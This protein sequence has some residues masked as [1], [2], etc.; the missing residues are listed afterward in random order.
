MK[1]NPIENTS[2][3][4]FA[5][6][7]I[8]GSTK[9]SLTIQSEVSSTLSGLSVC[10]NGGG[11]PGKIYDSFYNKPP[12]NGSATSP[13]V[14]NLQPINNTTYISFVPNGFLQPNKPTLGIQSDNSSPLSGLYVRT[15]DG[16]TGATGGQIY[17]SCFNKPPF[18]AT[19]TSDLDMATHQINNCN[20]MTIV[21]SPNV[22]TAVQSNGGSGL[23]ITS[24][25]FAT[26]TGIIYDSYYNKPTLT[27]VLTAGA[28]AGNLNITGVNNISVVQSNSTDIVNTNSISTETLIVNTITQILDLTL[29]PSTTYAGGT[30]IIS[31]SSYDNGFY[32]TNALFN[33]TIQANLVYT[34][35]SGSNSM[36]FGYT[37]TPTAT[38]PI[39]YGILFYPFESLIKA[40]PSNATYPYV[41]LTVLLRM[42]IS[43]N[44][45][46]TYINGTHIVSLDQIIPPDNYQMMAYGYVSSGNT[47]T[48]TNL[49]MTQ[50]F[51]LNLSDILAMGNNAENQDITGVKDLTVSQLNYTTLNPSI[52]GGLTVSRGT[53]LPT[54]VTTISVPLSLI[55][56]TG[57]I[58]VSLSINYGGGLNFFYD[59]VIFY[60]STGSTGS[61]Q[62]ATYSG[63]G[64]SLN[65]SYA[66]V[67]FTQIP[68]G[69]CSF[70]INNN[71]ATSGNYTFSY[72]IVSGPNYS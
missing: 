22:Y 26:Q 12:F 32:S 5:P 65:P 59:N 69:E 67:S 24:S 25:T 63:T 19:A 61:A 54:S 50:G 60:C 23:K 14:M 47:C 10:T 45:L 68:A 52:P 36:S 28:G 49:C 42:E 37:K 41:G 29:L 44:T 16:G 38:T 72:S 39:S 71:S 20:Q 35:N 55:N 40:I 62:M 11:N 27:Q 53:T 34:S 31:H 6:I 13:L 66:A 8:S 51:Y 1:V 7:G 70:Q 17:D 56:T 46:R 9:P 21:Q 15:D 43:G 33:P 30:V 18:I 64:S 48:L 2:Y 3:I 58:K 4:G 57:T